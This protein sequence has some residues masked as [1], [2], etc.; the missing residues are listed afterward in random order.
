MASLGVED[1]QNLVSTAWPSL[2]VAAQESL[3]FLFYE[4]FMG[5]W[6][7]SSVGPSI[8][9]Q[10]FHGQQFVSQ[11]GGGQLSVGPHGQCPGRC[12]EPHL[13]IFLTLFAQNILADESLS[14][15]LVHGSSLSSALEAWGRV[16]QLSSGLGRVKERSDDMVTNYLGW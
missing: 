16:L 10:Q 13:S 15:V 2:E 11:Q 12:P 4:G 8:S 14:Y 9:T 7:A 3:S 1:S 5:G 6:A